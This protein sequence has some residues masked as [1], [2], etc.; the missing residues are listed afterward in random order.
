MI[1]KSEN[2][3]ASIPKRITAWLFHNI[4]YIFTAAVILLVYVNT[5]IFD[6]TLMSCIELIV[7]YFFAELIRLKQN[8]LGNIVGAIGCLFLNVQSF[9][10][11][12]GNSYL[13]LTMLNNLA[14]IRDLSGKAVPILTATVLTLVCSFW[15]SPKRQTAPQESLPFF[16]WLG[17]CCVLRRISY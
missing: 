4:R 16:F 15:P 1:S 8:V 10:L 13:T 11:L 2:A 6:S 14:S 12:F 3:A 17:V 9:V 5:Q 7:L